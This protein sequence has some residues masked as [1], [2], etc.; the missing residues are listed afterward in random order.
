[1]KIVSK[2]KPA[3]ALTADEW[4]KH[5]AEQAAREVKQ[6]VEELGKAVELIKGKLSN[7]LESRVRVIEKMQWWQIGIMVTLVGVLIGGLWYMARESAGRS[8]R[9]MQTLEAH[10]SQS[11]TKP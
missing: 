1:M 10:V 5:V 6:D 2:K 3:F 8:E 11:E 7:G 9:M 4:A